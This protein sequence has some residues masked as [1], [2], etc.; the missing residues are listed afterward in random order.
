MSDTRRWPVERNRCATKQKRPL[1]LGRCGFR[2][3]RL[4][5]HHPGGDCHDCAQPEPPAR[6]GRAR[7]VWQGGRLRA[8]EREGHKERVSVI[9]RVHKGRPTPSG[10]DYVL[11]IH[12][13]GNTPVPRRKQKCSHNHQEKSE[14]QDPA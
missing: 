1:R 10:T 13:Q 6:R 7:N 4:R 12:L 14:R 3:S 8:V 5:G 11:T 2:S 9:K